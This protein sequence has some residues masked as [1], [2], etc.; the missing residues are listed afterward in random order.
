MFGFIPIQIENIRYL[1][2]KNIQTFYKLHINSCAKN[3][4]II[5]NII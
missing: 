1:T 2:Y 4:K 3:V 5:T